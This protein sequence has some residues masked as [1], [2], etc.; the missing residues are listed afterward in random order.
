MVR[1]SAQSYRDI[2]GER[3]EGGREVKVAA[4]VPIIYAST[5]SLVRGP[6]EV[7]GLKDVGGVV[8]NIRV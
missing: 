6:K 2:D 3:G 1:L 5:I 7:P 8:V 4:V